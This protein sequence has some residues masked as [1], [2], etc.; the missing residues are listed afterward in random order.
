M[1]ISAWPIE[2]ILQLPDHC[3]GPKQ[4]VGMIS[5]KEG[6][7]V[8]YVVSSVVLPAHMVV[9]ALYCSCRQTAITAWKLGFR[10]GPVAVYVT[11]TYNALPRVF[12]NLGHADFLYEIWSQPTEML[13][14]GGFKQYHATGGNRL[15]IALKTVSGTGYREAAAGIVISEVPTE[16]PNCLITNM[17]RNPI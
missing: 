1:D 2:S 13:Y 5:G 16:V 9:W 3:F 14:W 17:D 4:F 6:D 12:P 10:I 11:A 15:V 7:G 8:D